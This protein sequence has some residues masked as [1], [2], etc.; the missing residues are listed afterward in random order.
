MAVTILA[1][2]ISITFHDVYDYFDD[3]G[4]D[5]QHYVQEGKEASQDRISSIIKAQTQAYILDKADRMGLEISVEV[6]LDDS[7]N[8]VPCGVVIRG[9]AAP[10]AKEVMRTYIEDNLGIP[11][12]KQQWT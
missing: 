5:A 2:L 1:P 3:L 9:A 12:E 7:S 4:T 11:K 8:P 10:Y 6:E